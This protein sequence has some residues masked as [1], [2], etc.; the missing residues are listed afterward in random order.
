[1]SC[2]IG[3]STIR[4]ARLC[5]TLWL[6]GA[7]CEVSMLRVVR[8]LF[9]LAHRVKKFSVT[10]KKQNTQKETDNT[11]CTPPNERQKKR[12]KKSID[13]ATTLNSPSAPAQC[14]EVLNNPDKKGQLK[15]VQTKL[16]RRPDASSSWN[17]VQSTLNSSQAGE[18]GNLSCH[19]RFPMT[20]RPGTRFLK[21][22]QLHV[23]I[24]PTC[25]RQDKNYMNN[26]HRVKKCN[27]I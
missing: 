17:S 22:S 13:T 11:H 18:F 15:T 8:V 14:A 26:S 1:M 20:P 10:K 27:A 5:E 9:C 2:G 25:S 21:T 6:C 4:S 12:I 16:I 7:H 24:G 19:T 23:V 3:T